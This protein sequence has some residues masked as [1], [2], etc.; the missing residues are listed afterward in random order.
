MVDNWA[1]YQLSV[2]FNINKY[3]WEKY[4][5][6]QRRVGQGGGRGIEIKCC[7]E[8]IQSMVKR[9]LGEIRS[10]IR[11]LFLKYMFIF[12]VYQCKKKYH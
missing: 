5:S 8:T 4:E 10:E 11:Q 7:L 3:I 6:N 1:M 9:E 12:Y 2:K